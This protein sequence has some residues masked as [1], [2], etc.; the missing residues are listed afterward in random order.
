[1]TYS[2]EGSGDKFPNKDGKTRFHP[3]NGQPELVYLGL[4]SKA[5]PDAGVKLT[6]RQGND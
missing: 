4:L 6:R 2:I 1:M 5:S 3:E